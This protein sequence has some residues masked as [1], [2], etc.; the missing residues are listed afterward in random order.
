MLFH[1]PFK[2]QG[3]TGEITFLNCNLPQLVHASVNATRGTPLK[4]KV[5]M[6]NQLLILAPG[7]TKGAD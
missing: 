7:V 4:T 6:K 5:L 1:G 3:K 2:I